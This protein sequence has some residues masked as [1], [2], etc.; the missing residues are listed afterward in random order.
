MK[1]GWK[2]QAIGRH[3]LNAPAKALTVENMTLEADSKAGGAAARCL[4]WTWTG[5]P[6]GEHQGK[7][8]K[9]S[10]PEVSAVSLQDAVS[11]SLRSR[12]NVF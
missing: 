12:L 9:V 5:V 6:N 1:Q 7:I 4:L 10:L 2:T 3:L 11:R 8:D